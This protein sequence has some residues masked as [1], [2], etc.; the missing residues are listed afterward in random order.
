MHKHHNQKR[1]KET[2]T[3]IYRSDEYFC[4]WWPIDTNDY[5]REERARRVG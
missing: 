2:K 5:G 1:R 4:E 3:M